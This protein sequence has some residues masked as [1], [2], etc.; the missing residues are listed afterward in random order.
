VKTAV[1]VGFDYHVRALCQRMNRYASGWRFVPYPSSR[2]GLVRAL[3]RLTHADILIRVGG[4]LP[5]SSLMALAR[6]RG[7]PV[8]IIWAG[9]DVLTLLR[10]PSLL[11]ESQKCGVVHLAVAPWLVDELSTA[12]IRARYLPIIGVEETDSPPKSRCQ[13]YI[14]TYLPEPRRE[15]YGRDFVYEVARGLPNMRFLAVGAGEQDA[16]AP[17]N[18]RYLGWR[19]SLNDLYDQSFAILRVPEHDG[20]S[21]VVLEALAR[22]KFVIWKYPLPGVN[23]VSN[24]EEALA[25]LRALWDGQQ[26]E[27]GRHNIEGMT[28]IQKHYEAGRVARG[29]GEFLDATLQ[30]N[31]SRRQKRTVAIVGHDLFCAEV[32]RLTN[33]LPM[34]W[35]ANVLHFETKIEHLSSLLQLARADVLYSIGQPVL[36]RTV[37]AVTRLLNKPR[38]VHW[39][40]SDIRL[41]EQRPQLRGDLSGARVAHVA[42]IE[43]E[44]EELRPQ[45]IEAA[46]APLPPRFSNGPVLPALPE[47]FTILAYLPRERTAFYGGRVVELL[48]RDFLGKPV[49]FIIVGGGEV[50]AP[51]GASVENVG[52]TH[53][54]GEVYARSTVLVRFTGN[55]GL[56]LMVLEALAAGRQ[57]VWT[58]RFPF[59]HTVASYSDVR[60]TLA[61]LFEQHTAGLLT[62]QW[63]AS[64]YV[65]NGYAPTRCIEGLA[66]HWDSVIARDKS[67]DA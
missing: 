3:A 65:R 60:R 63:E 21:L 52:W 32:A 42:E 45:G 66:R 8:V 61:E 11:N 47:T 59:V 12:G 56:A 64:Q 15:F 5:H 16:G 38:V 55:D 58:K 54:L 2:S 17:P 36:G 6:L 33:D 23:T 41:L 10:N 30:E 51:P 18:V 46:I 67:D 34:V 37:G 28:F 22:G 57:V 40:G 53:T 19:G 50:E 4:P 25:C 29:L 9:T 44:V 49:R 48:I 24:P 13:P 7:I 26:R 43:W 39:V 27:P 31:A 35:Q 20:M 62:L 1:V 14:L